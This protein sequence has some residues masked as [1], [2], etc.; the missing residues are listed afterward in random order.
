LASGAGVRVREESEKNK[1]RGEEEVE[2]T[3]TQI[4]NWYELSIAPQKVGAK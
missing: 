3:P 2:L 4:L 1:R